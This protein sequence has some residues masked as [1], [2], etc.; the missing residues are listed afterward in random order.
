MT[1]HVDAKALCRFSEGALSRRKAARVGAHL[2]GCSRCAE[3]S[4]QL[5]GVTALLASTQ[6]P[7]IPEHLAARIQ[8]TLAT[9][10]AH[11]VALDP[12]S[13]PG[14]R[15]LPV[16]NS[17]PQRRRP[18]LSSP[19]ALRVLAAAGAVAVIAGSSYAI[20]H[21]QASPS[22][23]SGSSA[24]SAGAPAQAGGRAPVAAPAFGQV[25]SGPSLHY[26]DDGKTDSFV[27][28]STDTNFVPASLT[29][30]ASGAL[31]QLGGKQSGLS[32]N[33][34]A[35]QGSLPAPSSPLSHSSLSSGPVSQHAGR[36]AGIPV[37]V[38][39]GCVTRIAAD[40]TVLLVDIARYLGGPA[41]L[42]VVGDPGSAADH[43]WV[44]GP[45]C[46]GSNSDVL[47]QRDLPRG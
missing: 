17:R 32:R 15:E 47:A 42:I 40:H 31:A 37:D 2:H 13:E 46:S 26:S 43:L 38:L 22:S 34:T 25:T 44:V 24:S 6:P 3:L 18:R 10:S 28:V 20:V 12:G 35:G 7:P 27:P 16:R 41:T 1:R 5:A 21:S 29:A 45:A 14:R 9:E 30:Q 33:E 11:R 36:F 4:E 39:E 8:N 23:S 19:V